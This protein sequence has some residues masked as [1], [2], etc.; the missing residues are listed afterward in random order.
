MNFEIFS[1]ISLKT[2][3]L[4]LNIP[5]RFSNVFTV[6][7]VNGP[8]KETDPKKDKRVDNR[9]PIPPTIADNLSPANGTLFIMT[10]I[11]INKAYT[12]LYII[13]Y[14]PTIIRKYIVIFEAAL[15]IDII[16]SSSLD[17]LSCFSWLLILLLKLFDLV[18]VEL[19][20]SI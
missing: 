5:Y 4:N 3:K 13:T 19:S 10:S 16:K 9:E 17:L 7:F 11:G 14:K 2:S 20:L 1:L 18:D 15:D 8:A 6:S 12:L